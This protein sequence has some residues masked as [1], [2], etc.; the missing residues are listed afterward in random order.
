M[1]FSQKAVWEVGGNIDKLYVYDF[2]KKRGIKSEWFL[3]A[4]FSLGSLL[5]EWGGG[6][7]SSVRMNTILAHGALPFS[8]SVEMGDSPQ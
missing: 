8:A 4:G 3:S 1:K 5:G 7:V 2:F 6:G